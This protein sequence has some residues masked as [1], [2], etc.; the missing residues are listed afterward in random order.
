MRE[1]SASQSEA[2]RAVSDEK[3]AAERRELAAKVGGW[4]GG[5]LGT[6]VG[7]YP[8]FSAA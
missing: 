2:L 7:G 1:A 6:D 5:R 4:V 8:A 3:T